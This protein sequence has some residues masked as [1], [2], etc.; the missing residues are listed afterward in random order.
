[1]RTHPILALAL[2]AGTSAL[3]ASIVFDVTTTSVTLTLAASFGLFGTNTIASTPLPTSNGI[4]GFEI[5]GTTAAENKGSTICTT[6]ELKLRA[7][8]NLSSSGF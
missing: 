6:C 7:R 4:A 2:Q 1:M 8:G 3:Q 5:A